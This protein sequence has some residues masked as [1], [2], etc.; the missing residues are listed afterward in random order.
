MKTRFLVFIILCLT[1]IETQ[2]Q[3]AKINYQQALWPVK[4]KT[5]GTNIICKPGQIVNGEI[6]YDNL[7]IGGAKGDTIVVPVDGTITLISY[8]FQS[9]L[10]FS[11]T[12]SFNKEEFDRGEDY[13]TKKGFDEF[14]VKNTGGRLKCDI[15]KY[16]SLCISLETKDIFIMA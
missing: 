6:N 7:F 1:G 8:G 16:I 14:I 12:N 9:S 10:L 5:A 13:K 3:T 11:M 4:G 2:S 15:Q